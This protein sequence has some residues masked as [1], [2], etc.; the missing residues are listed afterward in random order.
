MTFLKE[1][2]FQKRIPVI[3]IAYNAIIK[4]VKKEKENKVEWVRKFEGKIT[5]TDNIRDISETF[6]MIDD[7]II[8]LDWL[9]SPPHELVPLKMSPQGRLL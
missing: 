9:I 4:L 5:E 1:H 8:Y 3:Q 7:F 2:V 6:P